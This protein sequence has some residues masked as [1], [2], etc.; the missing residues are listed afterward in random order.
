MFG[1]F[2]IPFLAAAFLAA[3]AFAP[4]A[5]PGVSDSAMA[6]PAKSGT[7]K[8]KFITKDLPAGRTK[9]TIFDRWGNQIT[10]ARREGIIRGAWV[11]EAAKAAAGTTSKAPFARS[12]CPFC[13]AARL[14]GPVPTLGTGLVRPLAAGLKAAVA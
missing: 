1:K 4:V 3:P 7:A 5:M 12:H 8:R 10:I 11:A 13:V 2:L 6:A 14:K 9:D